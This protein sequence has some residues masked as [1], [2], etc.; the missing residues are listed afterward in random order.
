VQGAGKVADLVFAEFAGIEEKDIGA[1]AGGIGHGNLGDAV[2]QQAAEQGPEPRPLDALLTRAGR[3]AEKQG[4]Q[5]Y[6]PFEEENHG[7]ETS[8]M[9]VDKKVDEG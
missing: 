6:F 7:Y 2:R 4:E 5:Q 3:R 8:Q 1:V 9:R